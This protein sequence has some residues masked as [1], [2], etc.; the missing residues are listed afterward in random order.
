MFRFSLE[1]WIK[2]LLTAYTSMKAHCGKWV[3]VLRLGGSLADDLEIIDEAVTPTQTGEREK[4]IA[5]W[6]VEMQEHQAK[7]HA[8]IKAE[9]LD[10]IPTTARTHIHPQ[11]VAEEFKK[12]LKARWT[13]QGDLQDEALKALMNWVPESGYIGAGPNDIR[14]QGKELKAR[15]KAKEATSASVDGWTGV[16]WAHHPESFF[17][18]LAFL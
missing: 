9:K 16:H 14:L 1:P 15:A 2:S 4:G 11:L 17:N 10:V 13:K 12:E 3:D 7:L 18:E 6:H 8:W 5:R